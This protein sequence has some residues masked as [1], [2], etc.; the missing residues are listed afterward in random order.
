MP[1]AHTRFLAF[2]VASALTAAPLA[3]R[4]DDGAS[5]IADTRGAA[6]ALDAMR[7]AVLAVAD[8][9]PERQPLPGAVTP[10]MR[11]ALLRQIIRQEL[12]Q[13]ARPELNLTR[14]TLARGSE[15][16][17]AERSDSTRASDEAVKAQG[18]ERGS[19]VADEHAKDL[20]GKPGKPDKAQNPVGS[21]VSNLAVGAARDAEGRGLRLPRD[22]R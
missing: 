7:A 13:E 1:Q 15:V 8:V 17:H 19:K 11:R 18:A 3:V 14:P 2:V 9:E 6:S 21:S 10:P 22:K 16:L 4:A 12:A 20:K 5:V